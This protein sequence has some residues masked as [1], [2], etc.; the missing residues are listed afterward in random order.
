MLDYMQSLNQGY[1]FISIR[2]Y[3]EEQFSDS[4]TQRVISET[5]AGNKD[6]VVDAGHGLSGAFGHELEGVGVDL[7]DGVLNLVKVELEIGWKMKW[8][9]IAVVRT[10]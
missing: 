2:N 8:T 6:L 1:N 5:D 9:I 7:A 4:R 3:L 10:N